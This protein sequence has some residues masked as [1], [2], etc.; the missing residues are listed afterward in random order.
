MVAIAI[1]RLTSK[2]IGSTVRFTIQVGSQQKLRKRLL[3]VERGT[4][5][6][7]LGLM[8]ISF[9]AL[10][11]MKPNSCKKTPLIFQDQI[12]FLPNTLCPKR[13]VIIQTIR[14]FEPELEISL[15]SLKHY[16]IALQTA[17][18]WLVMVAHINLENMVKFHM[19]PTF[20]ISLGFYV[21]ELFVYPLFSR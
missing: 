20:I 12:H 17:G 5:R 14:S 15:K 3:L 19:F 13:T 1:T 18:F 16:Q 10:I 7:P 21:S 4:N 6:K 11:K 8:K 9:I 2:V